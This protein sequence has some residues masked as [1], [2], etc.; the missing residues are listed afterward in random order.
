MFQLH[1]RFSVDVKGVPPGTGRTLPE[2][3]PPKLID[4]KVVIK[5]VI[6]EF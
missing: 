6:E 2:G 3:I 4:F 1:Q 5:I